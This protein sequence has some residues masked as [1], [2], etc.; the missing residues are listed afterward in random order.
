MVVVLAQ[1]AVGRKPEIVER[2]ADTGEIFCA[3]WVSVSERFWRM[4]RRTPSSSS[5][6]LIC[7]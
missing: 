1:Q 7:G 6:R 4:N 3:C 5:S 2:G